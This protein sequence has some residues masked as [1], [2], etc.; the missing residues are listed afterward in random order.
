MRF[1][2]LRARREPEA[3]RRRGRSGGFSFVEVM[4][5]VFLVACLAGVVA[6]A[7]PVATLSRT[8]ADASNAASAIA[9]KEMEAVRG[10]GYANL[11]ATALLAAGL[12]D[13]TTPDASGA[14]PFTNVDAG[15]NDSPGTALTG[16]TGTILIEHV[17]TEL[18]RV[19]VRVAWNER[20]KPRSYTLST[21]V[22]NL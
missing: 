5:A 14:F 11:T 7:M 9:Q 4:L 18:R 20:G 19:T 2:T 16:G 3:A 21:L 15:V 10:L 13:S 12:V 6:A 8:K 22:A 17:D 1:G